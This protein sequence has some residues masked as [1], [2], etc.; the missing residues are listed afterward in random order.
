MPPG[1]LTLAATRSKSHGRIIAR[2]PRRYCA[3][4]TS[5]PFTCLPS[6]FSKIA[7]RLSMSRRHDWERLRS[8]MLMIA[9]TQISALGRAFRVNRVMIT[10]RA[11]CRGPLKRAGSSASLRLLMLRCR[12]RDRAAIVGLAKRF[13][14]V[15]VTAIQRFFQYVFVPF[16][17][18]PDAPDGPPAKPPMEAL[19]LEAV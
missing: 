13:D 15:D 11:H 16:I 12:R 9:A 17:V 6:D 7:A 8:M 10:G 14:F 18:P 4:G 3:P 19:T 1:D 5:L 2:P